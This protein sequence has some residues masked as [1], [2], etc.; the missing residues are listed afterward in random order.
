[1]WYLYIMW[2]FNG[3]KFNGGYTDF[4]KYLGKGRIEGGKPNKTVVFVCWVVAVIAILI[5]FLKIVF[6]VF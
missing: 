1:V 4:S 2:K 6:R 3:W 5:V